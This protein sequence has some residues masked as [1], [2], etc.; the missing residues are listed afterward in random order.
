MRTSCGYPALAKRY[1][2]PDVPQ[3]GLK[4]RGRRSRYMYGIPWYPLVI[5]RLGL[6][7]CRDCV[8]QWSTVMYSRAHSAE[9]YYIETY[10][11]NL[12][13]PNVT[14]GTPTACFTFRLEVPAETVPWSTLHSPALR[15]AGFQTACSLFHCLRHGFASGVYYAEG[16][17]LMQTHAGDSGII[18]CY[19]ALARKS[20]YIHGPMCRCGVSRRDAARI[21]YIYGISW[22]TP[23]RFRLGLYR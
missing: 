8:V 14:L 5:F 7:R 2:R 10:T 6:N 18:V 19:P 3:W 1:S 11:W 17:D 20:G 15:E 9:T 12:I 23:I 16:R 22:Y 21:R 13:N 4:K